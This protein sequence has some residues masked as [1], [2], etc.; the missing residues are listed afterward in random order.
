MST[1]G[2]VDLALDQGADF[3]IQIYWVDAQKQPFTVLSPMRMDIRNE[4]GAII[5]SLM[6]DDEELDES[7]KTITY[8]TDSGLIQIMLPAARTSLLTPGLYE[9]DLFV[10][11]QDNAVTE[12][13]RL[14][15]LVAGSILVNG[16]VTQSV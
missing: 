13:T 10:T 5:E 16:R 6:T 8:N 14:K 1:A 11:Y 4:V 15:K 3:G 2:I 7:L 12:L 9:Y